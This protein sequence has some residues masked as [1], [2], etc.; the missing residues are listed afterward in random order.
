MQ[1]LWRQVAAATEAAM[2]CVPVAAAICRHV[3]C[4]YGEKTR[5]EVQHCAF[6]VAAAFKAAMGEAYTREIAIYREAVRICRVY[7]GRLPPLRMDTYVL[8]L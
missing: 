6:T 7:G 3:H 5:F 4:V 1:G 2:G 8:P